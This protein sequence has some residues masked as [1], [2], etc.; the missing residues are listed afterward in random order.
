MDEKEVTL[1][2]S[3]LESERI[4]TH[5]THTIS[6][7]TTVKTPVTLPLT[8]W[9]EIAKQMVDA[10]ASNVNYFGERIMKNVYKNAQ[11]ND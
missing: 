11:Q 6:D 4:N 9:F 1:K 5:T 8:K 3:P 10:E 7:V 2:L